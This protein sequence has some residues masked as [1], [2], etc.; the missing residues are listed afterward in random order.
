MERQV[1]RFHQ[2]LTLVQH[3]LLS[4]SIAAAVEISGV[5]CL[6]TQIKRI[7]RASI[8]NKHHGS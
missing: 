1:P 3:L 5:L 8:Y 6:V 7:L 4:N 2:N